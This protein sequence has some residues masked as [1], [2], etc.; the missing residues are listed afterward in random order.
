MTSWAAPAY[1][2]GSSGSG[3]LRIAVALLGLATV[4]V[5][6][7]LLLDPVAAARTLAVLLGIGFVLA[8]LL[9]IAVGWELPGRWASVVLGGILVLAGLLAVVWP[10]VTLWVLALITGLSLLLHGAGQIA[11]AVAARRVVRSW[12]WLALAG[13]AGVVVGVLALAWPKATVA[14]LSVILGAQVT[15]LGL[16]LLAAAFT[17]SGRPTRLRGAEPEW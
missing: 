4:I 7:V 5:G 6:V 14:V 15:V 3:A 10:G 8:G 11:L 17:S 9:E 12:R 2:R 1:Q 13:A 16:L